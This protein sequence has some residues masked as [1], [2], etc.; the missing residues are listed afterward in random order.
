MFDVAVVGSGGL[1]GSA[2]VKY[3]AAGG[4]SVV[5]VGAS[6]PKDYARDGVV[7][8]SHYDEARVARILDVNPVWAG[9]AAAS[10]KRFADIQAQSGVVFHNPVGCLRVG[11][12]ALIKA[13]ADVGAPLGAEYELLDT[14]SL[15][16][17]F[18]FVD[19][20]GQQGVIERGQAGTLAPRALVRAQHAIARRHG[21]QLI[22]DV[23]LR[24]DTHAGGCA[25]HLKSGGCIE[26]ARTLVAAGAF[27]NFHELLP[28]KLPFKA[29]PETVVLMRVPESA[30]AQNT[31]ALLLY[32]WLN[33]CAPYLYATP[34][35]R[36]PDGHCYMKVGALNDGVEMHTL[37]EAVAYF[38]SGGNRVS[39]RGWPRARGWRCQTCCR[40]ITSSNL[41]FWPIPQA[42]CRISAPLYPGDCSPP[43]AGA[44][45]RRS[46]RMSLGGLHP[47]L[48]SAATHAPRLSC[49]SK[50]HYRLAHRRFGSD[51]PARSDRPAATPSPAG[52]TFSAQRRRNT[53]VPAR[54]DWPSA[55]WLSA[56]TPLL[57][58]CAA[59]A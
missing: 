33:E 36:Y 13:M 47:N 19:A 29:M 58:R 16:E 59:Y 35:E 40:R 30:A 41:A 10:L 37:E 22:D 3:L 9:L 46:R 4:F 39:P 25:L 7:F 57:D 8:A 45:R 1:I 55:P 28:R 18:P 21:T 2:A 11:D 38:R 51:S 34:P 17:R 23:V 56:C 32:R 12:A 50:Q 52:Q 53:G 42:D 6:E 27:T 31:P 54:Q 15:A 26:A 48:S 44:A 14:A 49:R 5:G 43:P 24:I 20:A